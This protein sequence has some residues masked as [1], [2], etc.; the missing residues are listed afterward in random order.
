MDDVT[1]TVTTNQIDVRDV[2]VQYGR[3]VALD[4]VS[5]SVPTG[6]ITAVIGSNGAGKSTLLKAIMG[7]VP[8][9]QGSIEVLG[10]DVTAASTADIVAAGIALV[11][12]GRRLFGDLTVDENLRVGAYRRPRAEAAESFEKTLELFPELRAKLSARAGRLSG[13]QQQMVA[14][15]R[16]LMSRPSVLMLDEPCTGLAPII[17]RRVADLLVEIAKD[18]TTIL[19]VEQNATVALNVSDDC[20]VLETGKVVLSGSSSELLNNEFVTHAY[21]G[22]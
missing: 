20:C 12:E 21:L 5:V 15:G 13:G 1:T 18:G 14:I 6:Q 11:P 8:V 2:R 17:V 3:S 16:A 19:L 4:G 22:I 9:A 7:M 10:R